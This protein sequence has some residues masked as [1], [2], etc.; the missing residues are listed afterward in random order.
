MN[1]LLTNFFMFR[2]VYPLYWMKFWMEQ[3]MDWKMDL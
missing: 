1:V 3:Q 2:T